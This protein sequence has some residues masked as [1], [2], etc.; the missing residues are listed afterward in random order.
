MPPKAQRLRFKREHED[1][2]GSER[3]GNLDPWTGLKMCLDPSLFRVCS[4]SAAAKY[5]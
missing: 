1:V 3:L 5:L 4:R 2:G